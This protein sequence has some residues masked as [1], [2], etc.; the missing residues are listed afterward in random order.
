LYNGYEGGLYPNGTDTPP[1]AT[2]AYAE[3]LA[4]Q[5]QPLDTS[6]HV[7]LTRGRIVMLAIGFSNAEMEF[8]KFKD[9]VLND[10]TRNPK[11][12]VV[13]GAQGGR[14]VDF[15]T[16]P[17]SI[18]W[19][20]VNHDLSANGL[21]PAQVQVAWVKMAEKY[22]YKDG[23]FP[24]NAE[25]LQSEIE[26][27]ARNLTRLYPNI[28]IA[29][30][31]TRTHA[32]T[33]SLLSANPEPYAYETG[34][35]VKWAIQ[36]QI[37]GTGNLNYNPAH[38]PVVAP[39][40]LWGP[41]IW[42]TNTPRSD[43]F[44]WLESDVRPDKVHPSA[45]GE[46]KVADQLLA[47][48]KTDPTTAPWFLMPTDS[49]E[50]PVVTAAANFR[51]GTAPLTVN[52]TAS[53]TDAH[54][55]VTQYDWTYDDG[56]FSLNQNP[57]KT[58]DVPGIYLVHLTVSD[59]EGHTALTTITIRVKAAGSPLAIKRIVVSLPPIIPLNATPFNGA[60]RP[61]HN[62]KA[63]DSLFQSQFLLLASDE[64]GGGSKSMPRSEIFMSLAAKPD[65]KTMPQIASIANRQ[66]LAALFAGQQLPQRIRRDAS[67]EAAVLDDF[68][69]ALAGDSFHGGF[70]RAETTS[71]S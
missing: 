39:L 11:L 8:G 22:P 50:G 33:T 67:L 7:D 17:S 18:T 9:L 10:P 42:A 63:L 5:I 56:D 13:N 2:E 60:S 51:I 70:N 46:T 53:A 35:A 57:T 65:P 44:T 20:N 15:W 25:H 40:L 36:D 3:S 38:G 59:S 16:N 58:F 69:T 26:D 28:K 66:R 32:Y 6:G 19:R 61:S 45:R 12:V 55:R 23:V 29:Y 34:F 64:M 41:Y 54:G 47:F 30:L 1:A 37:N 31:S 43:G 27:V 49:G 14:D 52:F 71:A 4:L 21:T 24:A 68:V 48:F 62:L